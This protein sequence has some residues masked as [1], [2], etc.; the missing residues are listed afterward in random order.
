MKR[1][2]CPHFSAVLTLIFSATAFWITSLQAEPL[3]SATVTQIGG[4]KRDVAIAKDGAQERAA[5][6][7]DAVAGKDVLRTGQKSRAEVTFQDKS[8]ARLGSNTVFS[9]DP[10]SAKRE[11]TLTRGTALIH[12]PPGLDG[13]RIS[14]P[15]ATAAIRGDVVALRV[16]PEGKT[17]IVRLSKD[18]DVVVTFTKTGETKKLEVGQLLTIDPMAARLPEPVAINVEVFVQSSQIVNGQGLEK[19]ELPAS[20]DKEVK[21]AQE[22]QAKEIKNGNLEDPN[23]VKTD[24]AGADK[25][26][27]QG[28]DIASTLV[29]ATQ[30][31]LFAGRFVGLAKDNPPSSYSHNMTIDVDANGTFVTTMVNQSTGETDITRGSW[32]TGGTFTGSGSDGSSVSG[33]FSQTATSLNGTYSAPD[34][35][36]GTVTGTYNT[37]K[38]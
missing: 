29:Q 7:N 24:V 33:T 36:Y 19:K 8:F 34:P 14:S 37:N 28:T 23:R 10:Q 2:G 6:V 13:A 11:M 32:S 16:N 3:K 18:Q 25:S 5:V 12:V 9:F 17:Q 21:V 31:G 30:G 35:S 20:A 4:E 15:A 38:Q 27:Q 22:E 26:A 1:L